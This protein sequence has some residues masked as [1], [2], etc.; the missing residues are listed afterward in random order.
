MSS[1]GAV[2]LFFYLSLRLSSD[3]FQNKVEI[4]LQL[5]T[6]KESAIHHLRNAATSTPPLPRTATAPPPRLQPP[7]TR[8][9]CMRSLGRPEG[10]STTSIR[11]HTREFSTA[12]TRHISADVAAARPASKSRSLVLSRLRRRENSVARCLV[13]K[14]A[15]TSPFPSLIHP[16][17]H[18]YPS[19]THPKAPPHPPNPLNPLP[20]TRNDRIRPCH[21]SPTRFGHSEFDPIRLHPSDAPDS[22]TLADLLSKHHGA[23]PALPQIHSSLVPVEVYPLIGLCVGMCSVGA[24]AMQHTLRKG[25][26]SRSLL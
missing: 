12:T 16:N 13:F 10:H 25:D 5:R 17:P 4:S 26:V 22:R 21:S 11:T 8:S 2:I 14:L 18:H 9:V 20:P 7:T 23:N 19:H 6:G 3:W 24:F 1:I 15:S